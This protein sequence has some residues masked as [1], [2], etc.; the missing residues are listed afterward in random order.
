M[1]LAREAL[2]REPQ[3][4]TAYKVMIRTYLERN[5]LNMAKL[6]AMRATKLSQDPELFYLMGVIAQK[7]GDEQGAVL[8]YRQALR[9]RDDYLAARSALAEIAAKHRD[10]A[11]AG[12]QY[13]KIVQYDPK[14][15][16]ARVNLGLAYTGLGQVDKAMVEYDAA[17]KAN[18]KVPQPYY[19]LG[20]I[21]QKHKDAPE[22]AI[23]YYRKFLEVSGGAV[24]ADHPVFERTRECEQYV[25]QLQESKA[26]EERAKIEKQAAEARAKKDSE[27]KKRVEDQKKKE[28]VDKAKAQE[29]SAKRV[30][31]EKREKDAKEVVDAALKAGDSTGAPKTDKGAAKPASKAAAAKPEPTSSSTAKPPAKSEA[32]KEGGARG[33]QAA[34]DEPQ[35]S[36]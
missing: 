15:V 4:L 5:D 26:A 28:E 30:E 3:N 12:E 36:Y 31:R 27:E 8:Q 20:L 29:E 10:W 23:E 19:Y 32:K 1:R 14:N 6:V 25:R 13:K 35:D 24:P 16:A 33:A 34:T 7:E 21:F 18:P 11:N 2:M 17:L 22:K 9:E